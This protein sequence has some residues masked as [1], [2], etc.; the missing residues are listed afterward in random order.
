MEETDWRRRMNELEDRITGLERQWTDE[1]NRIRRERRRE[2]WMR[3]VMLVLIAVAYVVYL[4]Y[5]SSIPG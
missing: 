1:Q 3:L 5:V 2:R 4:Q